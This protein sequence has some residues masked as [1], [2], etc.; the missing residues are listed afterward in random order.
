LFNSLTFVNV[1]GTLFH[2]LQ[3]AY[4]PLEAQSLLWTGSQD[5]SEEVDELNNVP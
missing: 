2:T 3:A 4:I 5:G 1:Q